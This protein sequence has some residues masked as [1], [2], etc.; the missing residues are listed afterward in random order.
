L[1][2]EAKDYG[3]LIHLNTAVKEIRWS[4]DT[5]TVGWEPAGHDAANTQRHV[6]FSV[7]VGL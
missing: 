6:D 7:A 4:A 5:V 3:A 2:A 1:C